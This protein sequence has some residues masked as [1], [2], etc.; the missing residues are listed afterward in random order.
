MSLSLH[1]SMECGGSISRG[2]RNSSDM[3]SEKSRIG[4]ISSRISSSPDSEPG[5]ALARH[6]S[7]P[8]SHL[9]EAVCSARRSGT[10][11]GSV[12][13]AKE[14]RRGAR[15]EEVGAEVEGD[16]AKAGP[17]ERSTAG[18]LAERPAPEDASASRQRAGRWAAQTSSLY[19]GQTAVEV[20]W[21]ARPGDVAL[22]AEAWTRPRPPSSGRTGQSVVSL[23]INQRSCERT[24]LTLIRERSSRGA[25]SWL[26]VTV[27]LTNTRTT[28]RS[29]PSST[30]P[31]AET[32]A[33]L[34]ALYLAASGRT[35]LAVVSS[36]CLRNEA[37]S[38]SWA[39]AKSL[40]R[41]R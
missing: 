36:Y 9:N 14:I 16:A 2:S 28:A 12:M 24:R 20:A 30:T 37:V 39:R 27:W 31:A 33:L 6:S 22:L 18:A 21:R 1:S 35:P 4:L 40:L 17:S 41:W 34:M 32:S 3:V 10:S 25:L 29:R 11:S 15:E 5:S 8:I 23:S 19:T 26:L 38:R 13:R 7:L